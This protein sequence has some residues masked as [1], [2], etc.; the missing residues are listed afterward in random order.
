MD[1]EKTVNKQISDEDKTAIN[2]AIDKLEEIL[3][4][5]MAIINAVINGEIPGVDIPSINL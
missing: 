2:N 4:P 3:Y 5:K 1:T